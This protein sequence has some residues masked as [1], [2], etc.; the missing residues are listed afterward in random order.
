MPIQCPWF[1]DLGTGQLVRKRTS[2]DVLGPGPT[3]ALFSVHG[4]GDETLTLE[5]IEA[6]VEG[7]WQQPTVSSLHALGCAERAVRL[8]GELTGQSAKWYYENL[9][10][11][12]HTHK[13]PVDHFPAPGVPYASY[14]RARRSI[15]FAFVPGDSYQTA[16]LAHDLVVHEVCHAYLD[17]WKRWYLGDTETRAVTEV[18]SDWL[19][20]Y[21]AGRLVEARRAAIGHPPAPLSGR[22]TVL[23]RIAEVPGFS[24]VIRDLSDRISLSDAASESEEDDM[25]YAL[26]RVV[27]SAFYEAMCRSMTSSTEAALS[28]ALVAMTEA[29]FDSLVSLSS[30]SVSLQQLCESVA[31]HASAPLKETLIETLQ[32]QEIAVE[33]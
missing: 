17:G 20:V 12:L 24:F 21:S 1:L 16:C 10:I 3:S 25:V 2:V 22:A 6:A 8:L 7:D 29:I 26:A 4:P 23:S 15:V 11:Q 18:L 32:E 19:T 14:N 28:P 5:E 13:Y 30:D 9:R 33:G 31:S 27:S